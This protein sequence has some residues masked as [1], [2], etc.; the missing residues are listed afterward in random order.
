MKL[1]HECVRETFLYI[2]N[3]LPYDQNLLGTDIE[4]AEELRKFNKDDIKYALSKLYEAK[5][6]KCEVEYDYYTHKLIYLNIYDITWDGHKF[7]DTIRDPK[8]WRETKKEAK[9]LPDISL[10]MLGDIGFKVATKMMGL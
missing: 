4:E 1:N 5:F 8:V 7:L 2:E 9:K 3:T 6:I 10:T